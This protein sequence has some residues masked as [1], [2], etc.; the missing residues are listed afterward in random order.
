MQPEWLVVAQIAGTAAA[1]TPD[2]AQ[3]S[4][5]WPWGANLY[6]E[7]LSVGLVMAAYRV[8]RRYVMGTFLPDELDGFDVRDTFDAPTRAEVATVQAW[9]TAG[10]V[11]TAAAIYLLTALAWA[12]LWAGTWALLIGAWSFHAARNSRPVD[13]VKLLAAARGHGKGEE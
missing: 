1:P 6:D 9:F 10:V 7:I 4:P 12:L 5:G 3:F 8:G 11:V 2:L 13:D